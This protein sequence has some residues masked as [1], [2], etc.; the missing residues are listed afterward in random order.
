MSFKNKADLA[1]RHQNMQNR[2]QRGQRN[3]M[4]NNQYISFISPVDLNW[5]IL[6][7]TRWNRIRLWE[8]QKRKIIGWLVG[9]SQLW[10]GLIWGKKIVFLWFISMIWLLSVFV[11]SPFGEYA[12][13]QVDIPTENAMNFVVVVVSTLV[14]W[15]FPRLHWSDKCASATTNGPK[16]V[17]ERE[18]ETKEK[19]LY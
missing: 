1:L 6:I 15:I 18:R 19:K 8:A 13:R 2:T 7:L 12:F 10:F 3:D 11:K 4:A 17:S 14:V 5:H 9:G 16:C